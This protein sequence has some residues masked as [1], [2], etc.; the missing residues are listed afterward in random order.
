[1][2]AEDKNQ[3]ILVDLQGQIERVTYLDDENGYT[4]AVKNNKTEK[5]YT[6]LRNRLA[7]SG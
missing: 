1:M 4:I 5:R 2:R 7:V 6:Y 3:R